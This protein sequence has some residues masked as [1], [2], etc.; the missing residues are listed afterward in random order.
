MSSETG[1]RGGEQQLAYL[2]QDLSGQNVKSILAVKR[3]SRLE[4]FAQERKIPCYPVRFSHSFDLKSALKIHSICKHEQIDLIHLHTSKAQG[5]GVVSTLYGNRVPMVLSRRVAFLPGSNFF[6]RWK[7]NHPQI[8]KILCVSDKI[9]QIMQRYVTD[10]SRCVTVYSGIDLK[11]FSTVAPDRQF[12]I[13]EFNLDPARKI[14]VAVGAIDKS[15][16]HFT[17][18]ETIEKLVR[19]GHPVQGLLV[20]DGPLAAAVKTQVQERQL[21]AYVKFAGYRKDVGKIMLSAD[22]FL[23]TSREEG[24]GTSLLDAFLARI[25]VV[26]TDAGGIPEIVIHERTGLLAPVGNSDKLSGNVA[27]LLGDRLLRESLVEQAYAFVQNFSKE[28]TTARTLRVYKE[29]LH[30]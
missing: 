12:L 26:A 8:K 11:K 16:D 27:R 25:P 10:A 18:V 23:M 30:Q 19:A 21:G 17:F 24:L 14:I 1:W 22:I 29:V 20:G 15:K 3:E 9:T 5:V 13:G 2:L 28:E 4:K 7:Y 6:T